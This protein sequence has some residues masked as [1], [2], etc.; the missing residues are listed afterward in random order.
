MK[1]YDSIDGAST[2][3]QRKPV[4]HFFV[5]VCA[6]VLSACAPTPVR[7]PLPDPSPSANDPAING[8]PVALVEAENRAAN[9][10]DLATLSALWSE[11]ATVIETKNTPDPHDDYN[12]RG[13]TAVMDRYQVA[14]FPNPPALFAEPIIE[15]AQVTGD[16][17]TLERGVDE[18]SFVQRG[19][20]WWI[21]G[22]VIGRQ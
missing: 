16:T 4:A 5:L 13:K 7:M 10:L 1:G 14:V 22:L 15:V 18:W 21:T 3:R 8:D 12:W 2:N 20:R 9:A 19:G 6:L 17:A 11:E